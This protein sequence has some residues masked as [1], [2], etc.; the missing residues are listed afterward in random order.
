MPR[1]YWMRTAEAFPGLR[2][3]ETQFTCFD[4]DKPERISDSRWHTY[5]GNVHQIES[6]LSTGLWHWSMIATMPGKRLKAPRRGK[7]KTQQDAVDALVVCYK[8]FLKLYDEA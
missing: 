6:G 7:R 5:I 8:R 4:K 3:P 1:I 2:W